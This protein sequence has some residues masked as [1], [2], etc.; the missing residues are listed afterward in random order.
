MRSSTLEKWGGI[1]RGNCSSGSR[2]FRRRL[3]LCRVLR[4]VSNRG[5]SK[6]AIDPAEEGGVKIGPGIPTYL[7]RP[8]RPALK[9]RWV[10]QV[11][12]DRQLEVELDGTA[13]ASFP[14]RDA[15]VYLALFC[16]MYRP[17]LL[18]GVDKVSQFCQ[19]SFQLA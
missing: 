18:R 11:E 10:L 5:T 15:N 4:A 7:P 9:F 6:S 13:P 12:A 14:G 3:L 19:N 17:F 1:W 16:E 2:A 8:A